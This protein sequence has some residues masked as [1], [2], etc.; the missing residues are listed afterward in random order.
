MNKSYNYLNDNDF[1][2]EKYSE[3]YKVQGY[4]DIEEENKIKENSIEMNQLD[5]N[6]ILNNSNLFKENTQLHQQLSMIT[7]EYEQ[8]NNKYIIN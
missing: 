6:N 4:N 5:K 7:E 8:L 3:E 2:K 1:D